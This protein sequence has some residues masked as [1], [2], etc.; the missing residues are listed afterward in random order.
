DRGGLTLDSVYVRNGIIAG[1]VLSDGY[2]FGQ[3]VRNDSGRPF[4]RGWNSVAG[5]TAHAG[6]G[7]FFASVRG[8]FQHAPG[9]PAEPLAVREA[10]ASLDANPLQAAAAGQTV[11]RFR[12]V[13]ASAGVRLGNL[14]VS[15]G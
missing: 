15:V 5:F 3:T 12:A 1:P 8:E 4:G 7:R 13:E 6:S 9:N 10:I 14:N 2:H 11:N